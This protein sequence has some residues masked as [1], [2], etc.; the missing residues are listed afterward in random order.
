V[1]GWKV[2][3]KKRP[4]RGS[5]RLIRIESQYYYDP[6][7]RRLLKEV[8]GVRTY[9]VYADEGLVAETDAAGNVT[10][11]YGYQPGST[12]TTDPLFMK[13]GSNY[14]FYQND[15]LGTTQMLT[16][17][18][19]AVVW[20][21][22]YSSF[23]QADVDLSSTITNN[24]RFSGQYFDYETGLHFNW[25][26]F[27]DP[28]SGRYISADPIGLD[29]GTNLYVYVGGNPI[30]L[31]D[32]EGLRIQLMG[33][34]AERLYTLNQLNL[35]TKGCLW[36][37]AEGFLYRKPCGEENECIENDIDELINSPNLYRI[38]PTVDVETGFGRSH[39]VPFPDG[40]GA[41][42]YFDPNLK[43]VEYA[44]GFLRSKP[45]TPASELAHEVLGRATQIEHG[46]PHGGQGSSVRRRSNERAVRKANPAYIRMKMK[47]RSSYHR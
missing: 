14:Y 16:A 46:I 10:K 39:T 34:E 22:K 43:D 1:T 12:W 8:G 11:S 37:D 26:R 6:F 47:P 45:S 18:N 32:P 5:K 2:P 40:K 44:T 42:I 28:N 9:F 31:I 38:H 29:G 20:S 27:Y 30:N 7:G 36:I 24:L 41:D 33:D 35:F 3:P 21:A 25:H 4:F 15:H 19:G 13:V 17:V 23:G